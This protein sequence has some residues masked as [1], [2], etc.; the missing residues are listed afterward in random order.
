VSAGTD[1]SGSA[2]VSTSREVEVLTSFHNCFRLSISR[3][4]VTVDRLYCGVVTVNHD[5]TQIQQSPR[6]SRVAKYP[7]LHDTGFG[8]SSM[9]SSK[10][11]KGGAT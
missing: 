6:K 8:H 7:F 3:R 9:P 1:T 11:I 5:L 10:H 4:C 2:F